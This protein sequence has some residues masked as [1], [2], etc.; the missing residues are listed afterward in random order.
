MPHA[1][2]ITTTAVAWTA[3]LT[4]LMVGTGL[5]IT[6]GSSHSVERAIW[7]WAIFASAVGAS[8]T[9]ALL[10]ERTASRLHART[11]ALVGDAVGQAIAE[12]VHELGDGDGDPPVRRIR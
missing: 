7:A 4:L 9:C 1:A 6:G 2:T 12:H 10:L 11:L 8:F 5:T 3:A